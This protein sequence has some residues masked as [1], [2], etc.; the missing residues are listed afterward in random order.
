MTDNL[1]QFGSKSMMNW[2]ILYGKMTKEVCSGWQEVK[3]LCLTEKLL[4]N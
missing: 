2:R 1:S 4:I 3:D